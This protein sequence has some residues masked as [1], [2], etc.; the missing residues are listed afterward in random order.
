M[1]DKPQLSRP[2]KD[3][4]NVGV[5]DESI[6]QENMAKISKMTPEEIKQA[7]EQIMK[8]L[9]IQHP[10]ALKKLSASL[11]SKPVTVDTS[12]VSK[13]VSESAQSLEIQHESFSKLAV[14]PSGEL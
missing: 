1:I 3:L 11:L 5:G 6:S 10:N 13:A 12:D 9:G 2:K 14:N 8:T 4:K 7:R